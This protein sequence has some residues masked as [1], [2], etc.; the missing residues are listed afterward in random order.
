MELYMYI[1]DEL[2]DS[3][4]LDDSRLSQPGY[5]GGKKRYLLDLH[6]FPIK[7]NTEPLFL[8]QSSDEGLLPAYLRPC[9]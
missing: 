9:A 2:V 3:L 8:I 6:N 1:N 5:I 4:L 7:A